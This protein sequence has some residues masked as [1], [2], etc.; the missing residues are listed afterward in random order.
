MRLLLQQHKYKLKQT[1][2]VDIQKIPSIKKNNY[3]HY[4]LKTKNISLPHF[5]NCIKKTGEKVKPTLNK[6]ITS[7]K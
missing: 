2:N 4:S 6:S 1:I 7:K 5:T 3:K